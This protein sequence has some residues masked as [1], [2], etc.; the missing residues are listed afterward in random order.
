MSHAKCPAFSSDFLT[1]SC[2]CYYEDDYDHEEGG[3]GK[4]EEGVEKETSS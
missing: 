2:Y 4:G 3:E 1:L